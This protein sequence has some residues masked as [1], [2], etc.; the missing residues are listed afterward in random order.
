[1]NRFRKFCPNV[2]V[3][4]CDAEHSKGD[5]IDV[6]TKYGKD[7]PCTVH[8]LVK[9]GNGVY[10]YS[11]TRIEDQSYAERKA[12]RYHASAANHSKKSDGYYEASNEGREFL[13][14]GEPIKV[15]HHSEH[16]HRAMIER[17]RNRM[18]K[19]MEHAGIA[20]TAEEKAAYWEGKAEEITL[21]MPESLGYFGSELEK[22]IEVHKRLK[23]GTMAREHAYSLTYAAKSVKELKNKVGIATLLWEG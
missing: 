6:E 11:I 7:V 10:Y 22:A 8:N 16:R 9:A 12:E 17:N 14:L 23:D 13:A 2:Y 20:Q 15:G 19:C 21:A 18:D 5:I 4:E 3:A 1:M